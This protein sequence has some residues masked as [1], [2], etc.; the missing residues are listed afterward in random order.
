[1]KSLDLYLINLIS[2]S[3]GYPPAPSGLYTL[4]DGELENYDVEARY[5]AA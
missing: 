2:T 5:N 3:S 1:M 4:T